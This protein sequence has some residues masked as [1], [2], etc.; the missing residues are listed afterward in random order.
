MQRILSV[1]SCSL[2]S[3]ISLDP[4]SIATIVV[5]PALFE[6]THRGFVQIAG[7]IML[8]VSRRNGVKYIV[9]LLEYFFPVGHLLVV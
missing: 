7:V 1:G 3:G 5:K 9:T 8:P 4:L 6:Y 2:P